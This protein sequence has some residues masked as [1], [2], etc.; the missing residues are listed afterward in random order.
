MRPPGQDD[1]RDHGA[2]PLASLGAFLAAIGVVAGAFG[3]HA[4]RGRI[5]P[6]SLQAFETGVRYQLIHA[7]AVVVAALVHER[8]PRGVFTVAA[9][10]FAAGIVL[11]SGS[12]YGLSLG[13]T[14]VLGAV[15]PFGGLCFIA[16]WLAFAGGAWPSRP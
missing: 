8:R 6:Q 3:A 10:L 16:G 2:A 13:G 1:P 5:E 11:F 7:L 9:W 12:L 14:R 4:L 15:T